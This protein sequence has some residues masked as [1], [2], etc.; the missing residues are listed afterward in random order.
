MSGDMFRGQVEALS[1]RYRCITFDHRGQGKSE[2]TNAGYDMDSLSAD[3][4]EL[5]R[6]LDCAPRGP[7]PA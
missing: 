3:A 7:K 5:I 6:H 4:V 1:D 2:V